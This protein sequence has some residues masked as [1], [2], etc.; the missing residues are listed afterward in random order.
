[1]RYFWMIFL[2]ICALLCIFADFVAPYGYMEQNL[3]LGA[4]APSWAHIFGT[5]TLGRDIF[6]RVLFGGRISFA[7]GIFATFFACVVGV[8]YGTLSAMG[9]KKIDSLMMRIIDILYTMPFAVFVILLMLIFG[10]S[11]WL[12]FIAIGAVEWLTIA[13]IT[14]ALVL[15]LKSR[16]YVEASMALGLSPFKIAIKHVIP[17][18]MPSILVCAT[19]TVPSV[20]L[21]ESFLSFLGLGVQAPLPSWGTLV[22]EGAEY[23]ES[24]PWMLIFPSLIFSMTLY[25]LNNLGSFLESK[26]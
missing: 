13:R 10:R 21:L 26:R 9:G 2:F 1:M 16:Q 17:N 19:L 22:K 6:S 20:M 4:S 7:V 14:R 3:Q 23:L 8:L 18:A 11:I 24:A 5:D 25:A 12:I 15:D